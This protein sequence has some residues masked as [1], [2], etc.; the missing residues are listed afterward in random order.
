MRRCDLRSGTIE[1]AMAG[2]PTL[3]DLLIAAALA[4]DYEWSTVEFALHTMPKQEVAELVLGCFDGGILGSGLRSVDDI[5]RAIGRCAAIAAE[6]LAVPASC[7]TI[8]EHWLQ[9]EGPPP[10]AAQKQ[11]L[12]TTLAAL[13][14]AIR[15]HDRSA[16]R[17]LAGALREQTA[18]LQARR[19]P[20]QSS[21]DLDFV[22]KLFGAFAGLYRA[23][24]DRPDWMGEHVPTSN[25]Y[26]LIDSLAC[27]PT[28]RVR[29]QVVYPILHELAS[30]LKDPEVRDAVAMSLQEL[31]ES[32][33][34]GDG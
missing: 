18:E 7:A 6:L 12:D 33:T 34:Q 24:F 32:D 4:D 23:W 3:T 31:E 2:A 17:E 19:P 10:T 16:L 20:R 30:S 22:R 25:A 8:A 21:D 5:E 11:R 14:P 15:S 28:R 9:A 26:S 29:E 1:G 13:A 27:V